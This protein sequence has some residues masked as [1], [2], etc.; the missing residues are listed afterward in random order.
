MVGRLRAQPEAEL[1]GRSGLE[2]L[3]DVL[4]PEERLAAVLR[5]DAR[6]D[7]AECDRLVLA[8]PRLTFSV[9]DCHGLQEGLALLAL[10]HLGEL[11]GLAA[12]YWRA[13]WERDREGET[14]AAREIAGRVAR[15]VAHNFKVA[16]EGWALFMAGLG[17]DDPQS[18][19]RRQVGWSWLQILAEAIRRDGPG[20]E[21]VAAVFG[22]ETGE[23][24]RGKTA[25]DVAE[26]L[27]AVLGHLRGLWS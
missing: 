9:P 25:E 27:R 20:P 3:Y 16:E 26:L 2:R 6:G 4:T 7:A 21:E 19:L 18:P 15:A 8:A 22:M 24:E 14:E 5:A 17:A 13:A 23:A 12:C 11:A 10:R 1:S